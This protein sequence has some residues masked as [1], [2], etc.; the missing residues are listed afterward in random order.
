ENQGGS[1]PDVEM[2][3]IELTPL[4]KMPL[5]PGDSWC[6]IDFKW[7]MKWKRYPDNYPGTIDNAKLFAGS[8]TQTLK[9]Y[10]M[11]KVDY[12]LIP[13]ADWNKL[14]NWYGFIEGQRPIDRKVVEYEEY[15]KYCKSRSLSF[16]VGAI[17]KERP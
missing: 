6:L 3:R 11:N 9:K 10:C 14:V 12:E 7:F 8:E 13:I 2:Q 15:L 1:N 4:V 17:S 5:C 16:R